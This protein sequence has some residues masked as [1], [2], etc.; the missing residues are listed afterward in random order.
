MRVFSGHRRFTAILA[1]AAA[2]LLVLVG[3]SCRP[4]A[5]TP[6]PKTDA[7][8][9]DASR[10]LSTLP[11]L[12]LGAQTPIPGGLLDTVLK[13][14]A[15]KAVTPAAGVEAPPVE[16]LARS[17][18]EIHWI[19]DATRGYTESVETNKAMVV[20]FGQP[21][22]NFYQQFLKQFAD[23]KVS[24]LAKQAIWIQGNTATDTVARNIALALGIDRVPTV[25]VLEPNPEKI[26]EAF[27]I[28]GLE[29]SADELAGHLEKGLAKVRAKY[30]PVGEP[31]RTP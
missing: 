26:V 27:R 17:A 14:P 21:E 2:A 29:D 30:V 25:S 6:P 31:A 28:E 24:G 4:K 5:Q 19:S 23:P 9:W 18:G 15:A 11:R 1:L 22:G 20:L 3:P 12:E 10:P 16:P 13:Q 8:R 7:V